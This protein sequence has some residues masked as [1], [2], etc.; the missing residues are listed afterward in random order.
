MNLEWKFHS[1]EYS[2]ILKCSMKDFWT[3]VFATLVPLFI[4]EVHNVVALSTDLK[5]TLHIVQYMFTIK[6]L[7]LF[8]SETVY[9]I[10]NSIST[11]GCI[12]TSQQRNSEI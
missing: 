12:I 9:I 6:L 2:M 7:L 1:F 8:N 10:E 11:A 5:K 4:T 3:S